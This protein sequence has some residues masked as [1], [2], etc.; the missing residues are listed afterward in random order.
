[1]LHELRVLYDL[2]DTQS[3]HEAENEEVLFDD[4]FYTDKALLERESI[5]L[6]PQSQWLFGILRNLKLKT[7]KQTAL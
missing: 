6:D 5:R 4:L 1:M 7:R 2:R 3:E